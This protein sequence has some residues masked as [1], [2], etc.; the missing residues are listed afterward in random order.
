MWTPVPAPLE[1]RGQAPQEPERGFGDC[2]S[3]ALEPRPGLRPAVALVH[4]AVPRRVHSGSHT[5]PGRSHWTPRAKVAGEGSWPWLSLLVPGPSSQH[6]VG[7]PSVC[8]SLAVWS[9]LP[10]WV[11]SAV[12]LRASSPVPTEACFGETQLSCCPASEVCSPGSR[13]VMDYKGSWT[14][15]TSPPSSGGATSPRPPH[16]SRHPHGPLGH[17]CCPYNCHCSVPEPVIEMSPVQRPELS[18]PLI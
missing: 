6:R 8:L 2:T 3:V 5:P 14:S 16:L 1:F 4:H 15:R 7:L 17:T 11:C 13:S 10:C 18:H 12:G 9:F